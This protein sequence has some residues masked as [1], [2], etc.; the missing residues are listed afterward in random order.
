ML[1]IWSMSSTITE[2]LACLIHHKV[3]RTVR[4]YSLI[5]LP[6]Y[7]GT[8]WT[9]CII[10]DLQ[11]TEVSSPEENGTFGRWTLTLYQP[12]QLQILSSSGFTTKSSDAS[13]SGADNPPARPTGYKNIVILH[14][15]KT[16][17]SLL[18]KPSEAK[19]LN[20]YCL[21]LACSDV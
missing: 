19:R 11:S 7:R 1:E 20:G 4:A 2:L 3:F 18:P 9:L 16:L 8:W 10:T 17:L 5:G 13:Y 14:I 21:N 6:T 15:Y 12:T